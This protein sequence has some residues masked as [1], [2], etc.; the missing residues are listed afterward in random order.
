MQMRR[1]WQIDKLLGHFCPVNRAAFHAISPEKEN[2]VGP[3]LS[4]NFTREGELCW[5]M[6]KHLEGGNGISPVTHTAEIGSQ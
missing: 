2:C 1:K 3:C 6:S 5:T 4:R